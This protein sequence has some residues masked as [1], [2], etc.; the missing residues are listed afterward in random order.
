MNTITPQAIL[1]HYDRGALWPA[2]AGMDLASGYELALAVRQLRIARG[3]VPR[4]FKVGFTNRNIWARYQVFAPMWGTVWNST[5]VSCDG[6]GLIS[7][8]HACQPRLEPE[9]VF[10][11]AVTPPPNPSMDQLFDCLDWVAPGFE[12]VQSHHPN[13]VFTAGETAADSGLHGRLLVGAR[14]PVREVAAT[15]QELERRLALAR[16]RLMRG[17]ELVEEGAGANVL[18][19]PLHALAYFVQALRECP[20]APELRAGDVVTTGTWTDAW[21]VAAGETWVAQFD[22]PLARLEA[23][24]V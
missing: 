12:L 2:S 13:W 9:A 1:D 16:V 4:G 24:M 6:K 3:E 8:A 17:A 20:G 23:T 15:A 5:L 11:I 19:G 14:I 7:L 18:D 22:A 10:G 21:P